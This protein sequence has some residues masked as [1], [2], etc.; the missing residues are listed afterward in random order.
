RSWTSRPSSARFGFAT[1][2]ARASLIPV[3]TTSTIDPEAVR[4]ASCP[5]EPTGP[6]QAAT[7]AEGDVVD[8]WRLKFDSPEA[9]YEQLR[10]VE[11][12]NAR[13]ER[14]LGALRREKAELLA[15]GADA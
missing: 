12:V 2:P 13:H 1:S 4:T 3:S 9:M 5:D 15:M 11:H 14:E 10:N 7:G 6:A 8:D